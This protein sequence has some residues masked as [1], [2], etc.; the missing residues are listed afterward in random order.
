MCAADVQ[1][2][3][4]TKAMYYV[5]HHSNL[6]WT[7]PASSSYFE[8]K[9]RKKETTR[10]GKTTHKLHM[11]NDDRL[12]QSTSSRQNYFNSQPLPGQI[13]YYKNT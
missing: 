13:K 2:C 3:R 11:F 10:W 4:D 12:K 8:T 7:D 6:N 1:L 9:E 5:C